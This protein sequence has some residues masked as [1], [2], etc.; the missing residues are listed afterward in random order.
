MNFS[1]ASAQWQAPYLQQR[2]CHCCC[3]ATN[4]T[5]T[6]NANTVISVTWQ[7]ALSLLF[8]NI[9]YPAVHN[10]HVA[11]HIH[12]HT[13][14][15]IYFS[16]QR[17]CCLCLTLALCKFAEIASR[18]LW[19]W[20]INA[21]NLLP[22]IWMLGWPANCHA[23]AIWLTVLYMQEKCLRFYG[24]VTYGACKRELLRLKCL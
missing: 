1:L 3:Q 9:H 8:G 19:K 20:K 17:L 7:R 11:Q 15:M 13:H 12:T 14:T 21:I 2:C 5:A 24:L 22:F 23:L 18:L 16:M 10:S 4:W 6:N